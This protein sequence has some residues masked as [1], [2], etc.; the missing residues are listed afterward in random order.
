VIPEPL[1]TKELAHPGLTELVV[2]PGMHER[3]AVMATRASAFLVLPGGI[4]T[5]EEFFEIFTWAA[6]GLH[7]KPIGIL[8]V[9]GYYGP[10]L[11]MLDH[12]VTEKFLRPNHLDLVLVSDDPEGIVALLPQVQ[13]PPPGPLWIDL[14]RA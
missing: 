13:P 14:E 5:F 7:N 8:N 1:L 12:A 4:G 2:V 11:R 9:E 6:L 3:K 10:L